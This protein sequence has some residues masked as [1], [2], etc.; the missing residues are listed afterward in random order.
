MNSDPTEPKNCTIFF[1]EVP[2][3]SPKETFFAYYG[4][5]KFYQNYRNYQVSR[6]NDQLNGEF[7][8]E[9]DSRIHLCDPVIYMSDLKPEQQHMLNKTQSFPASRTLAIPCGLVA[10][11]QFNDEFILWRVDPI[12]NKTMYK[13][14]IN[15]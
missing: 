13:V 7:I 15:T 5:T 6:Q 1:H 4:L 8:A 11:S 14:D 12:T 2:K 9:S 10:K 3:G